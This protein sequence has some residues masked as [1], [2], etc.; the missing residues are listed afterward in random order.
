MVERGGNRYSVKLPG[1]IDRFAQNLIL[2][3]DLSVFKRFVVFHG[4]QDT[5]EDYRLISIL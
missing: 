3:S 2:S 5:G 4:E 1:S